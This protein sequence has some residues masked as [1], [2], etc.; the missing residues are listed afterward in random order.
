MDEHEKTLSVNVVAK[1]W[2]G[3][4]GLHFSRDYP[5]WNGIAICTLARNE[6]P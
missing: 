6:N 1:D 4:K 5:K 3:Q 2:G